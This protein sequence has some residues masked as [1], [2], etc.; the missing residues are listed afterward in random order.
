VANGF[1]ESVGVKP[2]TL[3]RLEQTAA[4]NGFQPEI[5]RNICGSGE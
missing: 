3:F 5:A 2:A 1:R 4:F